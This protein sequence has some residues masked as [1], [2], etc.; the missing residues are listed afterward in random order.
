MINS[1]RRAILKRLA[2]TVFCGRQLKLAASSGLP[3]PLYWACCGYGHNGRLRPG[4]ARPV[5][6][7]DSGGELFSTQLTAAERKSNV[8]SAESRAHP[9]RQSA[10]LAA[11][12]RRRA[13]LLRSATGGGWERCGA[14]VAQT[15]KKL[16][17]K[18][19][20]EIKENNQI[21]FPP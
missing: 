17:D 11:A 6:V 5:A 1:R 2:Q 19:V 16:I 10:A 18:E 13:R 7:T 20:K 15:E 12:A 3:L 14:G 4:K 8:S 9:Q 21:D